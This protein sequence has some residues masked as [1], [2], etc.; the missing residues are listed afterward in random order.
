MEFPSPSEA[1]RRG[2]DAEEVDSL[3]EAAVIVAMSPF[4]PKFVP[5]GGGGGGDCAGRK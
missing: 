1:W 2:G 5:G 3:F 4:V